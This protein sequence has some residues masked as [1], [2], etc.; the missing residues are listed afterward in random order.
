[1]L[2]PDNNKL[3]ATVND[4]TGLWRQQRHWAFS[5]SVHPQPRLEASAGGSQWPKPKFELSDQ[6]G[7][8]LRGGG[9]TTAGSERGCV[10]SNNCNCR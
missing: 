9:R 5:P 7:P 3:D 2:R 4:V 10:G 6:C 8:L 1:M